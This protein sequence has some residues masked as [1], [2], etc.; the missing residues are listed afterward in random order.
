MH[1]NKKPISPFCDSDFLPAIIRLLVM[2]YVQFPLSLKNV[3]KLLTD[4]RIDIC[5]ETVRRFGPLFATDFRRK[6]RGNGI[7]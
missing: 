6:W 4:R 5:H 7:I 2:M 1:I 3:G